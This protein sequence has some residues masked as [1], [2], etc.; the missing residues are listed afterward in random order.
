MD[1]A[2]VRQGY[3]PSGRQHLRT[4]KFNDCPAIFQNYTHFL[5]IAHLKTGNK[6]RNR[7]TDLSVSDIPRHCHFV[8]RSNHPRMN[9]PTE[10]IMVASTK[11]VTSLQSQ[12]SVY[13]L[14]YYMPC[15]K[16]RHDI[17]VLHKHHA[18]RFH[19]LDAEPV[20]ISRQELLVLQARW[21]L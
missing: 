21:L 10:A 1:K 15:R 2:C 11:P 16:A 7:K 12:T 14:I 6:G 4:R 8:I 3:S 19:H 9:S 5:V 13:L 20:L 18:I 17:I